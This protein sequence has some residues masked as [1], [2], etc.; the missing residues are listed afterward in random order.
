VDPVFEE[1]AQHLPRGVR[2]S[3]IGE[4]ASRATPRPCVCGSMDFPVLKHCAPAR[5]GVDRAGIGM[6][7]GDPTT[8]HRLSR[9]RGSHRP[10]DDMIAVARMNRGVAIAVKNDGWYRLPISK[11]RRNVAGQ[12]IRQVTLLHGN[13]RGRKVVG[14][15]TGEARMHADCRIQL[16]LR[17]GNLF[18]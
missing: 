16:S 18:F 10:R 8:M 15:P 7:S 12:S 1:E 9:V 5:V 2:S 14:G 13:E 4:G 11:N 6:S 3:R 17:V